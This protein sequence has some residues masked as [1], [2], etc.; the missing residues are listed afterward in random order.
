M[1]GPKSR[2][3]SRNYRSSQNREL[4]LLCGVDRVPALVIFQ[5]RTNK[6][7][8]RDLPTITSLNLRL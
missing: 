3:L 2:G 8:V 1:M 7:G 4:G 6:I 5:Q